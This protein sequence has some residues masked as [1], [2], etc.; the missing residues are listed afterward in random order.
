VATGRNNV[1]RLRAAA[2][3]ADTSKILGMLDT[4]F[5]DYIAARVLFLGGLPLQA[6]VLSSTAIEK[7]F[8]AIMELR[9]SRSRGHLKAAQLNSVRNYDPKLFKGF[10]AEF[11][12]LLQ[13]CYRLRY[14]D[15]LPQGFNAV[16]ATREFVAELDSMAAS[17]HQRFLVIR[18]RA[19]A[20]L[21]QDYMIT[22]RDPRLVSDNYL[23]TGQDKASFIAAHPQ[24]VYEVR[25]FP[26]RGLMEALYKAQPKAS[27]GRFLREALVPKDDTEMQIT[28]S[29]LPVGGTES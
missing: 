29:F 21:R 1:K 13:R 20:T 15:D 4:A 28:L 16:V 19:P 17:L 23:L 3:T 6:A 26:K 2:R 5:N 18:E 10:N 7:Y 12:S 22:T 14:T 11:L 8:K 24:L 9:G 27:D 25:L